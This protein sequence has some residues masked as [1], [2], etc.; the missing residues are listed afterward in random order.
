MK[1]CKLIEKIRA[2]SRKR[3]IGLVCGLVLVAICAGLLY[4]FPVYRV[5]LTCGDKYFEPEDLRLLYF[6]GTPGDRR[7]RLTI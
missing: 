6:R 7:W 4:N 2:L 5:G 3:K 1:N